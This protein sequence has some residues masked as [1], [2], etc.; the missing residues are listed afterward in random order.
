MKRLYKFTV[1]FI[2]IL[3]IA[4][5]LFVSAA[6]S[7]SAQLAGPENVYTKNEIE[8]VLRASC[9]N[10][11]GFTGEFTYDYSRLT[12]KEISSDVS[13]WTFK[14]SEDADEK[15]I[16]FVLIDETGKKALKGESD[17][18]T[19][20]FSTEY[21]L[22]GD[23]VVVNA[24]NLKYS[25]GNGTVALS[26]VSFKKRVIDYPADDGGR[27][28]S[29]TVAPDEN[30]S[31]DAET[32]PL[33]AIR[34]KSLEVKGIKLEPDFEPDTK[35][36]Q[37]NIPK[38]TKQLEITAEPMDP[39]SAVTI[40]GDTLTS[41]NKNITKIT[42]TAQNGSVRTYKIYSLREA[43]GTPA[44]EKPESKI[45][46]VI[47]W[48]ALGLAIVLIAVLIVVIVLRKKRKTAK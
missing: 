21:A 23:D 5:M 13:G 25:A 27:N 31:S 42:V 16:Y 36:Y 35:N 24:L 40:S 41:G 34:L 6:K 45:N 10:A 22:V 2:S 19:L 12:L 18:I 17:L 20:T 43:A 33:D 9:N 7:G 28:D 3:C 15:N 26:D 48:A 11:K 32:D 8:V 14:Y 46:A 29:G 37:V 30:Q 39:T 44:D 4:N 1:A 47:L 38:D